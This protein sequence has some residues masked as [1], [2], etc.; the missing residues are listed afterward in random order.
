MGRKKLNSL[1]GLHDQG[2]LCSSFTSFSHPFLPTPSNS[3]LKAS[4]ACK[5]LGFPCL[6]ECSHASLIFP[7]LP[8]SSA[9]NSV[10]HTDKPKLAAA[11]SSSSSCPPSPTLRLPHPL[12]LS[13]LPPVVWTAEEL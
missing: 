7:S 6:G 8:L 13:P 11:F 1:L 4:G 9:L 5:S 3:S 2:L 10:T 12:S